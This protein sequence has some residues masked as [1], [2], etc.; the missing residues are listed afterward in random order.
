MNS[1]H[2]PFSDPEFNPY[3][4][5]VA[6][7]SD[8][9][10]ATQV[11]ATSPARCVTSWLLGSA[12]IVLS[13]FELGLFG[14]VFILSGPPGGGVMSLGHFA[15]LFVWAGLAAVPG[16]VGLWLVRAQL[17][18]GRSI[19]LGASAVKFCVAALVATACDAIF[20]FTVMIYSWLR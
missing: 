2:P 6:T 15:V 14:F 16:C 9:I 10:L 19:S 7:S 4:P 13:L 1:D 11:N 8:A 20:L 3:A 17:Q 5:P 12:S 18:A